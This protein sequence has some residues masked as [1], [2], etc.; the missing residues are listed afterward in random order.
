MVDR[1]C[2]IIILIIV[3]FYSKYHFHFTQKYGGEW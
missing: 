2:F 3:M 1:N